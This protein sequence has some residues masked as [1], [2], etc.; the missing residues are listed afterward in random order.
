MLS[1]LE[2]VFYKL[3]T[4]APQAAPDGNRGTGWAVGTFLGYSRNSNCYLVGT[5]SG[6]GVGGFE[7]T[8]IGVGGAGVAG[9]GFTGTGVGGESVT[10]GGGTVWEGTWVGAAVG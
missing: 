10:G 3:P 7:V 6:A 1:F 2:S 5:A 8:G 4:K 9:F